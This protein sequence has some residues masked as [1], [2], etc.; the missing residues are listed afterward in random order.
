AR[1]PMQRYPICRPRLKFRHP[2]S[3]CE[4][5]STRLKPHSSS[6]FV[7]S[8]TLS[9]SNNDSLTS[10]FY[11][12]QP[13]EIGVR[14]RAEHCKSSGL[15]TDLATATPGTKLPR[16]DCLPHR[17]RRLPTH[18]T[19]V[20]LVDGVLMLQNVVSRLSQS[21]RAEPPTLSAP[22][23]NSV[24]LNGKVR[25]CGDCELNARTTANTGMRTF[26]LRF[27]GAS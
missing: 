24:Q 12:V 4:N 1:H 17:T 27:P 9:V 25:M 26:D 21:P 20:S 15:L 7:K 14:A 2:R 5:Q 19:S 10:D 8:K 6:I 11:S 18:L 16:N 23:V 13:M 3:P 22:H